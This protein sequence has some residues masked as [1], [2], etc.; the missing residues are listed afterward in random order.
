MKRAFLLLL[1]AIISS[2]ITFSQLRVALVVGGHQ[3]SVIET[4]N[5]PGWDTL[6]DNYSGRTG[7]HAGFVA[8][9]PFSPNSKLY[10][11]PGVIFY[12]KGRKFS[13]QFDPSSSSIIS[14]KSTQYIN[15]IDIPLNLVLKFGKRGKFIIGGGPYA[16][17]FYNGKET[18]QVVGQTGILQDDKY[19]DLPV[20][21]NP[22]QYAVFNYGINGLIGFERGRVFLTANYS[23]G[24]NDFYEAKDYTGTFKHQVIGATLGIFLGKPTELEK[25]IKDKDKDGIPDEK[26]N[27]PDDAGTA[28][29]NGCPDKDSDG[30]AD[31]D[32]KCPDLPGL[33]KNSGCPDKDSDG[34]SDR[35]DNCPDIA[36]TAK[37][38]GC[39]IPD[40]DKDG[41]NDEEDKCPTVTG[42]S[43]YGGCPVPD[44][45]NDGINDEE[46]KCPMVKGT[47]ENSGC[48]AEEVKKEIIEQVN[49]AAKRIQF[50][51]AKAVL[52]PASFGVLDEV[53]QILKE[54]PKLRL[55]IEGH[56]SAD[57][58]LAFNMKLSENRA[59]TVKKYLLSKGIE[60]SRLTT[61]GYG[62]T[63]PV[64]NGKTTAEKSQNRRVELKLTN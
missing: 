61:K 16:G 20:G 43:R 39:P 12:M 53:V 46:D 11:Q 22:G 30:V 21:S 57:G 32:D 4:N 31:K 10:F 19:D 62:P 29:T 24:L 47:K 38:N 25:K 56:T 1:I 17:F 63:Q 50:Q 59:E 35:D 6:K 64:N 40:S 9:L 3:S 14:V 48:P 55:F 54:N 7:L 36:G 45:D 42:F 13:Q 44:T 52:Q 49:Y 60:E 51:S 37:Y 15:Y 26:D 8:D 28:A 18:L 27:C 58:S 41:V 34:V 33:V 5:I 23:R 2:T